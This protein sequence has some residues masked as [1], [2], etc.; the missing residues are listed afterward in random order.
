MR[1]CTILSAALAL[2]AVAISQTVDV[3]EQANDGAVQAPATSQR[4]QSPLPS[5]TGAA[6]QEFESTDNTQPSDARAPTESSSPATS[7][8]DDKA[9][10]SAAGVEGW[11]RGLQIGGVFM[12]LGVSALGVM[13]PVG[14]KYI[15]WLNIDKRA[16][17]VGKFFGAGVILATAFI[18]MLGESVE[19][20]KDDCLDG[21]MGDFESWPGAL[22]M[23]AVL[24]MHLIEY[25]MSS[26]LIK[27]SKKE[28]NAHNSVDD[29]EASKRRMLGDS[30]VRL[31]DDATAG[32][33]GDTP[34][35]AGVRDIYDTGSNSDNQSEKGAV[36]HVHGPLVP[37]GVAGD[38]VR[39]RLSTYILELG[40]ALHS[41]IVGMTLA[42]TGGSGFKTLLAAVAVHQFF[43]GVALGTRIA[44]INFQRNAIVLALMNCAVFAVTTPIGQ[45]IGICIRESFAPR[46]PS[47]LIIMGVLDSLS[48]GVLIYSAL[49]NLLVEEF[50]ASEFRKSPRRLRIMYFAAMYAGCATM[51]VIGIWT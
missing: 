31:A 12:I 41:I 38:Q 44:E 21:R 45:V 8:S 25:A 34:T 30:S 47:T 2:S 11:N 37:M 32:H 40:I 6:N 28:G 5:V 46:D 3:P 1:I 13:V 20:L 16:L 7:K 35:F 23:M 27:Q 29:E 24:A 10:C 15:R 42:V 19:A 48:A 33:G 49:V 39:K 22:A 18:H 9:E 26:Y 4:N 51:S 17:N 50:S 14:C 36:G 43:E